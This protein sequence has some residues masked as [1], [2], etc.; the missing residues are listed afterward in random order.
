MLAT[1]PQLAKLSRE[2]LKKMCKALRHGIVTGWKTQMRR[3]ALEFLRLGYGRDWCLKRNENAK[4]AR[5]AAAIANAYLAVYFLVGMGC[6]LD[7]LVLAL[8]SG[9]QERDKTWHSYLH[10]QKTSSIT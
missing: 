4:L 5:D 3:E 10:D 8:A 9:F 7:P 1:F 2:D 6:R